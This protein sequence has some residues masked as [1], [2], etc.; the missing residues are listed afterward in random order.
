MPII[1]NRTLDSLTYL[2]RIKARNSRNNKNLKKSWF[3]KIQRRNKLSSKRWQKSSQ[4]HSICRRI[5]TWLVKEVK[6]WLLIVLILWQNQ[7]KRKVTA[8]FSHLIYKV[9][10]QA[11]ILH[12]VGSN[13]LKSTNIKVTIRM[14]LISRKKTHHEFN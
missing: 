2:H 9:T 14:L 7:D 4:T 3:R 12:L 5:P 10:T 8:P 1:F 11:V 6:A 13:Q